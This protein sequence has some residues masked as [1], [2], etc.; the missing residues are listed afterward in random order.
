M[1]NYAR[2]CL[3]AW[4]NEPAM[5]WLKLED[6]IGE[7]KYYNQRPRLS[8]PRLCQVVFMILIT[9]FYLMFSLSITE[10]TGQ[11]S[12]FLA[13]STPANLL[14]G[15]IGILFAVLYPVITLPLSLLLKPV[16]LAWLSKRFLADADRFRAS[17]EAPAASAEAVS[18]PDAAQA[19]PEIAD[20]AAE[21]APSQTEAT[22][23]PDP[24]DIPAD[25]DTP[26]EQAPV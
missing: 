16:H 24:Q 8:F 13:D 12:Q 9:V 19:C 3:I 4:K 6:M 5:Y 18:K 22:P 1:D 2:H 26:R 11:F 17:L 25:V 20:P 14:C 7:I 21:S 23:F 15:G 10:E